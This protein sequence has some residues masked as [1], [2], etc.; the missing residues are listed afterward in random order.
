MGISQRCREESTTTD[1]DD[2]GELETLYGNANANQQTPCNIFFGVKKKN[3]KVFKLIAEG[4][5][6]I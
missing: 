3:R 4:C 2:K 1:V 6:F 5:V